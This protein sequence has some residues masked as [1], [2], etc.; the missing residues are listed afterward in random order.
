MFVLKGEIREKVME[1]FKSKVFIYLK[2]VRYNKY[3][4]QYFLFFNIYT[5]IAKRSFSVPGQVNN[6]TNCLYMTY[7]KHYKILF[8]MYIVTGCM[9]FTEQFD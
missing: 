4:L 5:D 6:T 9:V 1:A 7:N 8:T 2:F 3:Q